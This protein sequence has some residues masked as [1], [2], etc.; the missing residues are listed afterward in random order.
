[1]IILPRS[2]SKISNLTPVRVPFYFKTYKRELFFSYSFSF[3]FFSLLSLATKQRVKAV[4]NLERKQRNSNQSSEKAWYWKTF[5][6]DGIS[7]LVTFFGQTL[8]FLSYSLSFHFLY[9]F[10]FFSHL[11]LATKRRVK[12]VQNLE[13]KQSNSNQSSDKTWHWKTFFTD[14]ISVLVTLF[15]QTLC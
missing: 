9:L 3:L 10:L 4:Q 11:S 5:F 14:G 13:R 8:C 12:A 1:M 7:L 15:G 2:Q 6:T